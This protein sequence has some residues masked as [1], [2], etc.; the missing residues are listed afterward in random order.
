MS[1]QMKVL[2]ALLMC[3]MVECSMMVRTL[4]NEDK[5]SQA[6]WCDAD[7]C[8][9]PCPSGQHC[10]YKS[11]S[12]ANGFCK[13]DSTASPAPAPNTTASPG[14]A[15]NTTASPAPAPIPTASPFDPSSFDP[16]NSPADCQ[17]G[18]KC[19]AW[20]ILKPNGPAGYCHASCGGDTTDS[21][22]SPPSHNSSGPQ[23]C[24]DPSKDTWGHQLDGC[25]DGQFCYWG[26]SDKEKEEPGVCC[27][28][29]TTCRKVACFENKEC[30]DGQ[31]CYSADGPAGKWN[32]GV[33]CSNNTICEW[34]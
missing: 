28:E 16:C 4:R 20:P 29:G 8:T 6:C 12:S 10:E 34:D 2:F 23:T 1:A 25:P 26:F 24:G 19:C 14:P 15:P 32:P 30:N 27:P 31:Y 17:N 9:P 13:P 33:C 21:T 22:L 7:G 5:R 3:F 18:L 11:N